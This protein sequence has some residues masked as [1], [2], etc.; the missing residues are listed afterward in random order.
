MSKSELFD[1][2]YFVL[3]YSNGKFLVNFWSTDLS[4]ELKS[5]LSSF[6]VEILEKRMAM[7]HH[8]L[9]NWTGYLKDELYY[10][11]S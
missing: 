6:S 5:C 2:I 3:L 7:N 4:A 1:L 9:K 8:N 10:S 11:P